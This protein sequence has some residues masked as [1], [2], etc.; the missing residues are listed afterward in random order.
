L[1]LTGDIEKR[2]ESTL[3]GEQASLAADFLKVPHHGGKNSS[4]QAFLAAVAPRIAVVSVGE[5][6]PFGHP[7]EA[8]LKRYEQAGVRLLRTDRD[9]AITAITDG[10]NLEVHTY[11]ELHPQ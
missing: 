2:S 1:L 6:N 7:A 3:V 9:G 8:A 10:Q 5:E 11:A 4:T